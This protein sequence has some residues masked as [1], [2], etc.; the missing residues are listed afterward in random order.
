MMKKTFTAAAVV[1]VAAA[2]A[3]VACGGNDDPVVPAVVVP[4]TPFVVKL[5]GFNDYH[6]T[7]ESPG[8]FG[9]NTSIPAANRPAV[10]GAEFMAAH[11]AALKKLN[12]LNVVVGAGDFIGATPLVSSLFF[13]EP[14]I[15]TLNRIGV[16]FNAVGNH[17]FDKGAIELL[18]LQNGGCKITN[19]ATDPNSCKGATVGTPVPFEGLNSNGCR[20]TW[21]QPP[22]VNRCCPLMASRR[23]MASK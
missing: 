3:L 16:E 20:P 22:R 23:S 14:A 18:R 1:S 6:G 9:Q 19:G 2:S 11:V 7:L 15:E 8:T 13:D 4:T 12:P 21:C 5:I 17:E 10:G